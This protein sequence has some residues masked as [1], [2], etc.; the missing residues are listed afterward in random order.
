[1]SST[2]ALSIY[3]DVS[4]TGRLMVQSFQ[5]PSSA[6]NNAAVQALAG[7]SASKLEH[8]Y[9]KTFAQAIAID[10]ASE[11]RVIH[12]VAGATG[13]LLS[14][15][16]GAVVVAGSTTTVDVDLKKN[17]TTVLTGTITLDNSQTAYQLVSATLA[18]TAM[19][20]GDVLSVHFTLTGT[21][22]PKGVFAQVNFREDAQ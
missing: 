4:I 1:M 13:T 7:I 5:L 8:Q 20:V 11:A 3:G 9:E 15:K 6:V 10:C 19:A 12:V 22:E 21:N 2:L 14:F 16:A 18:S 17:G